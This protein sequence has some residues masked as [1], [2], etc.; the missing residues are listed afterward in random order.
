MAPHRSPAAI[1]VSRSCEI[2]KCFVRTLF[3][4]IFK[5]E[6]FTAAAEP[7]ALAPHLKRVH[8]VDCDSRV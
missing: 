1:Q 3:K 7:R 5:A 8:E 6:I 2:L 4:P